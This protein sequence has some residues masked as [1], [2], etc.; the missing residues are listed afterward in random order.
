MN[1]VS[2]KAHSL[3]VSNAGGVPGLAAINATVTPTMIPGRKI[4]ET[5][6]KR[7]NRGLMVATNRSAVIAAIP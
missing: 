2:G 6:E 7:R 5:S 1:A 3:F 4:A